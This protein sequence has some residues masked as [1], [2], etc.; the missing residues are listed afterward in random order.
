[1]KG[2][3][4]ALWSE[5]HKAYRSKMFMVTFIFFVFVAIMLAL[6]MYAANHPELAGRS[7]AI[8]EK[9]SRLGNGDWSSLLGFLVQTVL[10]IGQ[11]G[12]GIVTSW[13]FGREYAD[14]AAKDLLA[15]PT[16]RVSIVMAKFI[17]VVVW[18]VMLAVAF[19]VAALF[20]GWIVH[21]SGWSVALVKQTMATYSIGGLLTLLLCTPIAF[22]ASASRGYLLPIGLVILF[23]IITQ[24]LGMGL[25]N[26]V[27]Y[28]PWAIPALVSGAAGNALPQAGWANCM[29]LGLT[30]LLGLLATAFW[31]RWADQT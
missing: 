3:S 17:V 14:R 21:L 28:F 6:L 9:S 29:D 26:V 1:M 23:L 24:L 11:L 8:S 20:F 2:F 25:P 5:A 31:W 10:A 30:S 13:V 27:S 16:T 18:N 15:L 4:A 19:F 7:A 22:F 12:F